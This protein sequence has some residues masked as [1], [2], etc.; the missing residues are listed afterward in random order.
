[1]TTVK[2]KSAYNYDGRFTYKNKMYIYVQIVYIYDNKH[3]S[4]LLIVLHNKTLKDV[5]MTF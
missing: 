5:I 2:P 3:N 4:T 1:M